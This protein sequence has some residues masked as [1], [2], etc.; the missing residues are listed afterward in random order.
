MS[1]KSIYILNEETVS[2]LTQTTDDSSGEVHNHMSGYDNSESG[3]ENLVE[4]EPEE[5]VAEVMV[6]WGDA[7]IVEVPE[8]PEAPEQGDTI[9]PSE[10]TGESVWDE[11]AKAIKEGVNAI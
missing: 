2:I 11:M 7:P 4:N 3:R 1:E 5:I 10:S 6:V 9:S 8:F